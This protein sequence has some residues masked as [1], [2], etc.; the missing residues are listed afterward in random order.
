MAWRLLAILL[1]ALL[2]GAPATAAPQTVRVATVHFAPVLG[3]VTGNRAALVALSTEAAQ[4]GAKIIVNTE[5]ATSGYSYFSRAEL[6]GVAETVP[7]PTT[8]A[9]GAVAKQYGAYIAVGMP[10]YDPAL[11]S[12]FNAAVLIAPD[13]TVAGVYRKRNNLLEAAYN[14]EDYAAVPVFD[15]PYGKLGLVICADMFYAQ[16][17]R[18]A[19]VAGADI[20]LAPANVGITTDFMTVRTYEND[21]AMIVANRYGV[22]PKGADKDVFD[23]NS[24]SIAS[25]FA[26]DFNS[27]TQSVIMTASGQVLAAVT[28]HANQIGYGDLPIG[29]PRNFP[30]IRRPELYALLG[31]DTLESYTFTQ[32]GLPPPAIFAGA[33]IDPGPSST[34]WDAALSALEAALAEAKTQSLTLRL[35]VLPG[36]YFA[37]VDAK[38]FSAIGDFAAT[39]TVDV[40]VN[41]VG[42]PSISMLVA[43]N[44]QTYSYSQT[45]RRPN[46]PVP[47]SALSNS[48]WVVDRDYGRIALMQGTDMLPPETAIVLEKM[49]VDVVAVNVDDANP[50]LDNLWATR[51]G[52]YL[53]IIEANK[54]GDEGVFLGGYIANPSQKTGQGT[55][56]MELNTKDVRSK[57][58][59]RFFDYGQLVAPC[60]PTSC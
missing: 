44:G 56:I 20:L 35:A 6:S 49:G 50:I 24:F 52:D 57:K 26:Y 14:A 11:N 7:G 54:Q 27:G 45:H 38:G 33:A 32:F 18:A 58:E 41:I 34:P 28:A 1:A 40:L 5:M 3:D 60:T 23:Q 31:Q 8:D 12:Y 21:F 10:E 37:S 39:N 17:P 25:P 15:T 51:T 48:Y 42:S 53:H 59:P 19:A 29:D 43:S 30:V 55:V 22:E 4:N 47:A 9:L 16:F 46:S 2:G 13:G 36:N